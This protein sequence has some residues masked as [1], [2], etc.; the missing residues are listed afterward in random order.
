MDKFWMVWS[1]LKGVPIVMHD[2]NFTA[3]EEAGRLAKK[4]PEA[5]FY[6]LESIRCCKVKMVIWENCT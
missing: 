5:T 6:I 3:E 2:S 4:H 1:P